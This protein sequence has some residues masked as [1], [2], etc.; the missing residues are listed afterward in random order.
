M[1]NNA[2]VSYGKLCKMF[3]Y[4]LPVN[5]ELHSNLIRATVFQEQSTENNTE[6]HIFNDWNMQFS[7]FEEITNAIAS[8]LLQEVK[9]CHPMPAVRIKAIL[10]K[11]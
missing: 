2:N 4:W 5:L 9:T 11:V 6:N 10:K 3:L 7:G 1:S 8:F